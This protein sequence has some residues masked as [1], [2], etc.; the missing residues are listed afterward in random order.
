[1]KEKPAVKRGVLGQKIEK[2][3]G[4]TSIFM[5]FAPDCMKWNRSCCTRN[6]SCKTFLTLG[7]L[8]PNYERNA[9]AIQKGVSD[10]EKKMK[11]DDEK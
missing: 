1:M 9:P 7:V 2:E 11:I 8:E 10:R 3:K 6:Y 5:F 4:P